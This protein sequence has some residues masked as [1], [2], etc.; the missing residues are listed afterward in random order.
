MGSHSRRCLY[1]LPEQILICEDD[2]IN[3]Q[4]RYQAT[5]AG[6]LKKRRNLED[7]FL[8]GPSINSYRSNTAEM[9]R[10]SSSKVYQHELD[11][12]YEARLQK[13]RE[14]LRL[15]EREC[16][17]K[18]MFH[19]PQ[20]MRD[21]IEQKDQTTSIIYKQFPPPCPRCRLKG[22]ETRYPKQ[23]SSSCQ[24][25]SPCYFPR[26][27]SRVQPLSQN[28]ETS[29]PTVQGIP[30]A[31]IRA[32]P[33]PMRKCKGV[34]LRRSTRSLSVK[35]SL[36]GQKTRLTFPL[37]HGRSASPRR[38]EVP[39]E[40]LWAEDKGK[41]C[42]PSCGYPLTRASAAE[43]VSMLAKGKFT[44]FL[45][46]NSCGFVAGKPS[47]DEKNAANQCPTMGS[48]TRACNASSSLSRSPFHGRRVF[49]TDDVYLEFRSKLF[50][51]LEQSGAI[52]RVPETRRSL[53]V[54]LSE[55]TPKWRTLS[56]PSVEVQ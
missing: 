53:S 47:S 11:R 46:C 13:L 43:V 12:E 37:R 15:R 56:S 23:E 4:R 3:R 25:E 38:S 36:E 20:R 28:R 41:G 26:P 7:K 1:C 49:I 31:D 5:R 44:N 50:S 32:P 33:P 8:F 52:E 42:C 35:K 30:S 55:C 21:S 51:Q 22:H 34:P 54:S 9:L 14:E 45:H 40:A 2:I 39:I 29:P 24:H 6:L 19:R 17:Q 18:N 48:P 16:A 27:D 10:F